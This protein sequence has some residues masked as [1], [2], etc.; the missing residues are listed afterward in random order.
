M[1]DKI[2]LTNPVV[3]GP[4]PFDWN[5][6]LFNNFVKSFELTS[7]VVVL[8]WYVGLFLATYLIDN[9]IHIQLFRILNKITPEKFDKL[10]LELLNVGIETQVILKGIILLVS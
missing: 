7:F 4:E 10:S 5:L 9:D 6:Y 3:T 8:V 1:L 2:D